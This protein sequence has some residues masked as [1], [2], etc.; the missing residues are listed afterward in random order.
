MIDVWWLNCLE[1]WKGRVHVPAWGI[2]A[3]LVW[4]SSGTTCK[5]SSRFQT[6]IL[7]WG[8]LSEASV[9]TRDYWVFGFRP[10]AGIL[11]NT[12]SRKLKLF[13]FSVEM[14]DPYSVGTVRR[15]HL[16]HWIQFP[17]QWL[18][19]AVSKSTSR[20]DASRH[21]T[22]D[23]NRSSSWMLCSLEYWT[24]EKSGTQ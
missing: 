14:G 6:Q 24:K 21:L 10:H 4:K 18:G 22:E 3:A 2:V 17:E 9:L 20:I 11:M 5:A 13:S 19:L 15:A 12:T 7:M 16:S 8:L 23:R 1:R